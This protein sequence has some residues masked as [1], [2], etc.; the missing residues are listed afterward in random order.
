MCHCVPSHW[1]RMPNSLQVFLT[2]RVF[3]LRLAG[4]GGLWCYVTVAHRMSHVLST[5]VSHDV[6]VCQTGGGVNTGHK[7][8]AGCQMLCVEGEGGWRQGSQ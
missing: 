4:G 5:D 6:S 1:E 8:M 3:L 2:L 7:I